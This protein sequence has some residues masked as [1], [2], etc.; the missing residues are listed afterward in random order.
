MTIS[1]VSTLVTSAWLRQQI[2]STVRNTASVTNNLRVLD[3]SW[4]PSPKVDGFK[5][6]FQ[7]GHIPTAVYFDLRTVNP[8]KYDASI[9]YPIPDSNVFEDYVEELGISN[10]THV[11]VYD[12]LNSR[13]SFRT[14]FLFKL[15]GHS[16]VSV[17][18]GG[19]K[20]W[21]AE[22][23]QVTTETVEVEPGEFN[24]EFQPNLLRDRE[25]LIKNIE[26]AT[27]QVID[28]RDTESYKDGHIPGAK[29]IPFS[30]IFNEDGTVQ[31]PSE[32]KQL[33]VK[34]GVDP[35][36][37]IISSCEAGL[38]ACGIIVAAHILGQENVPLYNGS[39]RE[40][41]ALAAPDMITRSQS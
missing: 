27:E 33:F 37:P 8:P 41:E 26:T 30:S 17:L 3:S 32:L 40:W 5:E 39:F 23:N 7:Q 12:R 10:H 9:R 18:N 25:S 28:A 35:R 4:V 29:N 15:F 31:A 38:T 24:A 22:G 21:V 19:L 6:F 11:V 36:A 14:W 20:Q 2:Q 1:K 16:Q 34:A 13:S